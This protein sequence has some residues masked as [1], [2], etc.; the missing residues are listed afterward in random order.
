LTYLTQYAKIVLDMVN[1][2]LIKV[3]STETEKTLKLV[4]EYKEG[5]VSGGFQVYKFRRW[6]SNPEH[7]AWD[8]E[9]VLIE[10]LSGVR[11]KEYALPVGVPGSEK[12]G[13]RISFF[14]SGGVR[15]SIYPYEEE[16][17][18]PE[19]SGGPSTSANGGDQSG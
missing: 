7:G 3:S 14:D 18:P 1:V 8:Q 19:S 5:E 15:Y 9:E 10:E 17:S 4:L 6:L 13:L 2:R 12:Y 11:E 16:P